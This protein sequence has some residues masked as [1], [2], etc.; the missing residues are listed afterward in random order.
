M[1]RDA[2]QFIQTFSR[3]PQNPVYGFDDFVLS[4]IAMIA[5]Q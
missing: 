2:V 1:I 5:Y 4:A 3:F